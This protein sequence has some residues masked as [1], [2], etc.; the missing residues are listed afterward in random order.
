MGGRRGAD[1]LTTGRTRRLWG[2]LREEGSGWLGSFGNERLGTADVVEGDEDY[3]DQETVKTGLPAKQLSLSRPGLQPVH[4]HL[5]PQA[6]S[7]V[8]DNT[9]HSLSKGRRDKT[10]R[11]E[12]FP[13][14]RSRAI[15]REKKPEAS[16]QPKACD[17]RTKR[18]RKP[19]VQDDPQ[20]DGFETRHTKLCEAYWS[21]G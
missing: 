21:G 17:P 10:R 15:G 13:H 3:A 7:S 16:A 1:L 9:N 11:K 18:L 5:H 6:S 19:S 14:I 12:V 8:F 20:Q 4:L 2:N